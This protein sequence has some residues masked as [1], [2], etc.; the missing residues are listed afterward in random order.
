MGSAGRRRRQRRHRLPGDRIAGGQVYTT[1]ETSLS[2]S[3]MSWPANQAVTFTVKAIN[4]AGASDASA[5]TA[6]MSIPATTPAPPELTDVT[7][8][9]GAVSA[10]WSE[11][12]NGGF[13]IERYTLSAQPG[14]ASQHDQHQLRHHRP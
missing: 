1:P 13:P 11:P 4:A 6:P 10:T 3:F 8:Q 2:T 5:P 12:V 9:P 14:G 7:A